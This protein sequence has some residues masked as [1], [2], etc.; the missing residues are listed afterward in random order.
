MEVKRTN[1]SIIS[2]A[3]S[4][5]LYMWIRIQLCYITRFFFFIFDFAFACHFELS[6]LV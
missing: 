4:R 5:K 6:I 3:N 1:N 2:T